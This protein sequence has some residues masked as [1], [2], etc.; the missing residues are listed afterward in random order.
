MTTI[1]SW[2][3]LHLTGASVTEVA[4]LVR[5]EHPDLLLMQEAT[6]EIDRLPG[7]IG[8]FYARCPLPYRRHGLA[9]WSRSRLANP[10]RVVPIPSGALFDWVSQIVD[11][12]SHAV[13]NVH[14]SHGQALNRR[15]LRWIA[16][17]L[18]QQAAIMG[19]FNLVGPCLLPGF[20]DVGPRLPTHIAGDIVPLRI[21]RCIVRG[22]H[23]TT[24]MAL[25][26]ASSDHRPI[27][28]RL[29]A[30]AETIQAAA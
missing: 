18:P 29:E 7:L 25:S 28:V 26:R 16:R 13:A 1:I 17:Y 14:L 3:L 27:L 8:G 15:Q 10:P 11:F 23:C 21:D 20:R 22:F 30:A 9:V 24:A 19:D 12:G 6:E 4:G 5:Q 2:N